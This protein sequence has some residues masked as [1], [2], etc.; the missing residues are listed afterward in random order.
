MLRPINLSKVYSLFPQ[1]ITQDDGSLKEI[2]YKKPNYELITYYMLIEAER[3]W[4]G[5]LLQF[6]SMIKLYESYFLTWGRVTFYYAQF[7][8]MNAILRLCGY[9]LTSLSDQ[10]LYQI[11]RISSDSEA[12]DIQQGGRRDHMGYWNLYYELINKDITDDILL[13]QIFKVQ[14]SIKRSEI[15]FRNLINYD[16]STG[17][18]ER[19]N[20]EDYF[21][22]AASMDGFLGI[23]N[24]IEEALKWSIVEEEQ[25]IAGLI[26]IWQH[27]QKIFKNIA[28]N[29]GFQGYWKNQCELS[30]KYITVIPVDKKVKAW[31]IEKLN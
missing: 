13:K 6:F 29:T 22:D 21:K 14:M 5:G 1:E 2:D 27:L 11:K 16:L 10:G 24:N 9:S 12:Y 25:E 20:S 7:F 23:L 3:F 30:K 19:Y 26:Y 18:D 4:T 28:E 15:D 17:Y 8:M 31:F